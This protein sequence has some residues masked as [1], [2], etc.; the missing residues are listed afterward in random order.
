MCDWGPAACDGRTARCARARPARL[1]QPAGGAAVH[2][3]NFRTFHSPLGNNFR[4]FVAQRE[5]SLRVF[6]KHFADPGQL[7]AT[8]TRSMKEK[9][10]EFPLKSGERHADRR[11]RPKYFR[12]C[13]ADA[14][15]F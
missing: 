12:R 10:A 1:A 14:P 2:P 15:L 5:H 9:R 3:S 13:A 6:V 8:L 7:K 4:S 11:L